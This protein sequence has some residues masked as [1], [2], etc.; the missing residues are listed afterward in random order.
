M[1]SRYGEFILF[2]PPHE[3][4]QCLAVGGA[5]G[6]DAASGWGAGWRVIARGVRGWSIRMTSDA[7]G[8]T[9]ES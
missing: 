8:E 5:R 6:A 9:L 7:T 3:L 2:R 4:A 1:V